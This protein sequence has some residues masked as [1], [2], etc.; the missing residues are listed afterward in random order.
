MDGLSAVQYK[1]STRMS[2]RGIQSLL[3]CSFSK[4]LAKNEKKHSISL[5]KGFATFALTHDLKFASHQR[6]VR[7]FSKLTVTPE[8]PFVDEKFELKVSVLMFFLFSLLKH[9]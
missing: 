2:R 4:R 1:D 3:P 5:N 7:P 8:R 6:E 9:S